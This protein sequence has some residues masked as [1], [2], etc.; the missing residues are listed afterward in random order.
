MS[1]LVLTP[2]QQRVVDSDA[3]ALVVVAG[4]GSGKTEVVARRVERLLAA[5]PEGDGRVLA[6]SF[7]VKAADELRARV[8]DRLGRL[9]RRVDADTVHGFS[10][11]IVRQ[12]GTRIGL[13]LEPEVLTQQ[14]DRVEMLEEWLRE[15]GR[16]VDDPRRIFDELDLARAKCDES[17]PFLQEWRD[18]LVARGALDYPAMLDAA[19]ELLEMPAVGRLVRRAYDEVVV[20]E[21]QNLTPAQYRV[22]AAVLG[23]ADHPGVRATMVGDDRQSIVGFAGADHRLVARFANDYTAERHE[24]TVNHRSSTAVA[25]VSTAV[26]AALGSSSVGTTSYAAQGQVLICAA[27]DERSEAAIVLRWVQGLLTDGLEPPVVPSAERVQAEEVAVLCRTTSGLRAA[28]RALLDANVEVAEAGTEDDWLTTIR[29]RAAVALLGCMAAA[30]HRS[31]RRQLAA[32]AG[33]EWPADFSAAQLLAGA[34]VGEVRPLAPLAE[35]QGPEEFLEMLKDLP[36][37][38]VGWP[39]DIGLLQDAWDA[40]ADESNVGGRTFAGFRQF[41][42]RR[43]RGDQGRPG[44]RLLTI[45]KAQGQEFKAVAV[46]GLTNGQLPDFRA[47]TEEEL[48]AELRAFYV[49]VSRASRTML[50]TYPRQR[51]TRYGPRSTEPSPFL[52]ILSDSGVSNMVD[53]FD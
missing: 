42:S 12:F 11:A 25:E 14:A 38:D 16:S 52:R 39:D 3:G 10:L 7:T 17:A 2:E 44:V 22:I 51:E 29:A 13:P 33:V 45:H 32:L 21:A 47:R 4:A 28:R 1:D 15:Q 50:L 5:D 37:E 53:I 48:K 43:Q 18:C 40:F 24:L 20:D 27:D 23:P 36:S 9:H 8:R 35:A 19:A 30:T 34:A 41:L 26:A 46:I 49:A 6:V 31:A